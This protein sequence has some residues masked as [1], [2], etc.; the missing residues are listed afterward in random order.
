MGVLPLGTGNDLAQVMGWGNMCD[1]DAQVPAIIEKY[2]RASAKLLDRLEQV[3]VFWMVKQL[4]LKMFFETL[5]LFGAG[6]RPWGDFLVKRLGKFVP[7]RTI[8]TLRFED[9]AAGFGFVVVVVLRIYLPV[10]GQR[11]T[12][13]IGR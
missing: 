7:N 1:D 11:Q 4:V 10:T 3:V 13:T 8:I 2:E 6:A 9:V 12:L 5:R